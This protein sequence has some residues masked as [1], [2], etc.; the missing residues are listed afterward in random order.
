MLSDVLAGDRRPLDPPYPNPGGLPS[1]LGLP[2]LVIWV[3]GLVLLCVGENLGAY[4]FIPVAMWFI[5]MLW[6]TGRWRMR[7]LD[8]LEARAAEITEDERE[9]DLIAVMRL[10]GGARRAKVRR[11][12]EAIRAIP[13]RPE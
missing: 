13:P 2:L 12:I 5:L 9:R 11:R 4:F 3:S 6:R 7:A 10:Y 1:W 8:G